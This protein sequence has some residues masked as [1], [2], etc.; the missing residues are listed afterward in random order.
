MNP[1]VDWRTWV[2]PVATRPPPAPASDLDR[3]D[4]SWSPAPGTVERMYDSIVGTLDS[5]SGRIETVSGGMVGMR[6][7]AS[8]RTHFGGRQLEVTSIRYESL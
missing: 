6:V 4:P 5:V 3:P 2:R 8:G 1:L 7:R